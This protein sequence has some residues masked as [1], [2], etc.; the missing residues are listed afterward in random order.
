MCDTCKIPSDTPGLVTSSERQLFSREATMADSLHVTL[1]NGT[2]SK[3]HPTP[4]R[5]PKK[6]G[7]KIGAP[8]SFFSLHTVEQTI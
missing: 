5:G 3:S 7:G 4:C 1:I 6:T 8:S 2:A